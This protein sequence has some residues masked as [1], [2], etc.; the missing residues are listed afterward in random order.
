MTQT[1][2]FFSNCREMPVRARSAADQSFVIWR[3]ARPLFLVLSFKELDVYF[4]AVDANQFAS[5]IGEAGRREQ[6]KELLEI[7]TLYG[8]LDGQYR[9]AV[10]NGVEQT[11]AAPRSVNAH[12][13]DAVSPAEGHALGSFGVVC[14]RSQ[15]PHRNG[16]GHGRGNGWGPCNGR[17][18]AVG[19]IEAALLGIGF[20]G[21]SQPDHGFRGAKREKA[22][23]LGDFGE[24]IED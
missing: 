14:H 11:V 16:P 19:P 5:A 21:L 24:A 9:F 15:R 1:R 10:R 3:A 2:I 4:G 20:E 8:A 18:R 13:A 22:V 7:E 17:A 23:G 12:D 6:Q